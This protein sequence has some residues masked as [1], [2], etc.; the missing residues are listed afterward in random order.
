MTALFVVRLLAL[1]ASL[2]HLGGLLVAVA[3]TWDGFDPSYWTHY[4]AQV[5]A[6]PLVGLGL[7]L[8]VLGAARPLARWLARP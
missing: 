8:A 3:Q 7:S 1:A 4:A 2:I 5:L 6:G